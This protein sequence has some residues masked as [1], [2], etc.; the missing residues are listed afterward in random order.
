ER[1]ERPL[2]CVDGLLAGLLVQD[3][4]L[5]RR[6]RRFRYR[7]KTAP[8][9]PVP[10]R[11]N[12]AAQEPRWCCCRSSLLEVVEILYRRVETCTIPGEDAGGEDAG[13]EPAARCGL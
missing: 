3:A 10:T 12:E 11:A 9:N 13:G 6:Y 7:R 8:T 1:V 2:Y 4:P 5:V